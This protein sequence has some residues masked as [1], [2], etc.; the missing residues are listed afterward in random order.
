MLKSLH[1][2]PHTRI[3]AILEKLKLAIYPKADYANLPQSEYSLKT[4][5][6]KKIPIHRKYPVAKR[7]PLRKQINN[8]AVHS[9]NTT[10]N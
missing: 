7:K 3:L 8:T 1:N 5:I 4:S 2:V 9:C 6:W 10:L